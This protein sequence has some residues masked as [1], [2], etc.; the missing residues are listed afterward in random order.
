MQHEDARA[1]AQCRECR[2]GL[3]AAVERDRPPDE[4]AQGH[5][6][7]GPDEAD[8]LGARRQQDGKAELGLDGE[9]GFGLEAIVNEEGQ[10]ARGFS[11]VMP[12][13]SLPS[14]HSRKA[15]PAVET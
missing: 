11:A 15:P 14:S 2:A 4:P 8:E 7:A 13:S 5:E 12:G 1:R 9:R 10:P 6:I 3:G